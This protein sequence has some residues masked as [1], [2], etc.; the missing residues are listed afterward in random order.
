MATTLPA[1]DPSRQLV[2]TDPDDP[3]AP[4]AGLVGDTYTVLLSGKDTA[5][6]YCLNRH[7]MPPVG[8]PPHRHDFEESFTVLAGEIE[9]KLQD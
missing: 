1:A 9:V 7:H 2:V 8:G 4:Y 3:D 6:R 5:G